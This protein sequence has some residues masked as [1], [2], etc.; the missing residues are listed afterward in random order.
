MRKIKIKRE[1]A[2][3]SPEKSLEASGLEDKS[4][5]KIALEK[6]LKKYRKKKIV[7]KY[8]NVKFNLFKKLPEI[9]KKVKRTPASEIKQKPGV[10]K[11]DLFKAYKSQ[12]KYDA[13]S[14][15]L[16]KEL[17]SFRVDYFDSY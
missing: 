6:S 10:F 4:L 3:V 17:K 15:E 14:R 9:K 11:K 13:A 1:I 16:I 5:Q 2:S 12:K 7:Y 8:P